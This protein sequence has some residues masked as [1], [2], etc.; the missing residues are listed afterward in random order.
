MSLVS[1]DLATLRRA[2][3]EFIQSELA[4]GSFE[5][6][7]DSWLGGHSPE[8]SKKLAAQGWVGMT[9]PPEYGG[10]GRSALERFV[11]VEELL[12]HG[13]PVAAHWIADRQTGPLLVK[14]GTE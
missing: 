7:C 4:A 5:P 2:V 11:V 12:A 6:K 9:F 10:G 13:A 8:F 3:R 14:Y 1:Q